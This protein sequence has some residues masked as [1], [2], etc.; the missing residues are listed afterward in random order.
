MKSTKENKAAEN[1]EKF[2]VVK[3]KREYGK[4]NYDRLT[5]YLP[6]G[7]REKL[8]KACEKYHAPASTIATE[9]L[10]AFTEIES[11]RGYDRLLIRRLLDDYIT[12]TYSEK[13]GDSK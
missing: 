9:L 8:H 11:D 4:T 1:N 10:Y 12:R 5:L 6:K 2:D 13:N 3:Y 7:D